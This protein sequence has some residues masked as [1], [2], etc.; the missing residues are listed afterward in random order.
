TVLADRYRVERLISRGGMGAVFEAT[1]LGL[2]R[3]V[4][5]KMLL[6]SLSR[7]DKMQM[8]FRREAK[9]AAQLRHPNI[10]QIYDYGIS[11]F[12]PYIVMEFERV[13]SLHQLL[14]NGQLPLEHTEDTMDKT[15]YRSPRHTR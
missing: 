7:D 6:P 3:P 11:D 8:R 14:R 10:I 15:R 5:V 4:A 2:D 13:Q 9:S 12:G 1:Q